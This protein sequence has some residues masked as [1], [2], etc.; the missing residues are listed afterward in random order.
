MGFEVYTAVSVEFEKAFLN[1]PNELKRSLRFAI[2]SSEFF[3]C[4]KFLGDTDKVF[5]LGFD[6]DSYVELFT[7]CSGNTIFTVA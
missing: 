7:E 4:G 2:K 1:A 3:F 6:I 5:T